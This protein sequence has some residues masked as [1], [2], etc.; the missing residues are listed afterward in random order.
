MWRNM[1]SHSP[2]PQKLGFELSLLVHGLCLFTTVSQEPNEED[3]K[4]A[5]FP[6]SLYIY[7]QPFQVF[8]KSSTLQK[9]LLILRVSIL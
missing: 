8:T 5:G 2:D 1:Q 3:D 6:F 9:L 7:S 4:E